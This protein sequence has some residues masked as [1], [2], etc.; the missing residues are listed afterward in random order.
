MSDYR[1]WI[2]YIYSYDNGAKSVNVGYARLELRNRRVR[3]TLYLNGVKKDGGIHICYYRDEP[4]HLGGICVG[5]V[6]GKDAAMMFRHET[7]S[8][9]M[10]GSGIIFQQMNGLIL[11]CDDGTYMASS[12]EDRELAP[13]IVGQLKQLILGGKKVPE[14]EASEEQASEEEQ[15]TAAEE[16]TENEAATG[17]DAKKKS[18]YTENI[19]DE[20][21]QREGKEESFMEEPYMSEQDIQA[22]GV[23]T[24]EAQKGDMQETEVKEQEMKEKETKKKEA[25]E[26]KDE[27]KTNAECRKRQI[28]DLNRVERIFCCLTPM[29]PF[30]NGEFEK[31]VRMEPQDIGMLPRAMWKLAGN[32]FLLH[33]YYTYQHLL[34]VS[35]REKQGR[36]Y[37]L[38]LPGVYEKREQYMAQMYGFTRFCP[39]KCR[40]LEN[41]T[42]G[43]WYMEVKFASSASRE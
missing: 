24:E 27:I 31:G 13:G 1:R 3:M 9:D 26:Q 33:A 30:D 16:V 34:F 43:Y 29:F 15:E 38:M 40:P 12:W 7:D 19:Q 41:G 4:E 8:D 23:Q 37:Y 20:S 28:C 32:S 14:E 5:S 6:D 18:T 36:T 2:S 42:F 39:A 25:K 35:K 22:E 17:E 21:T 11:F 10:E